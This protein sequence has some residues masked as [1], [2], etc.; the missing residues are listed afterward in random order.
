MDCWETGLGMLLS[1]RVLGGVCYEGILEDLPLR[2]LFYHAFSCSIFCY[3]GA[4]RQG[5]LVELV[6]WMLWNPDL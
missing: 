3:Y 2:G 6:Q 1:G 4:I 5:V